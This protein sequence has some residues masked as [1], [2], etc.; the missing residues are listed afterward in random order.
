VEKAKI[1]IDNIAKF[2]HDDLT[3]PGVAHEEIEAEE[4]TWRY[5]IG[6]GGSEM[7]HIQNNYKVKVNIPRDTSSGEKV[8]VLG[9]VVDVA[10]AKAY[11]EKLIW[12]AQQ[13]RGRDNKNDAAD[14]WGEEGEEEDWMKAY[15]SPYKK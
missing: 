8:V 3:H 15:M 5:I 1:V 7:R 4:W 10:R 14:P 2:G 6:K 9:L 13:P 11:I 12:T